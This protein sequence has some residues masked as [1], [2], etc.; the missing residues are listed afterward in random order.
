MKIIFFSWIFLFDSSSSAQTRP[1]NTDNYSAGGYTENLDVRTDRDIYI[2]G[3]QIWLK[4]YKLS[5]LTGCPDNLSKI[6]YVELLDTQFNPLNQIKV[7]VEGTSGSAYLRLSDTLTSGNYLIRAYTKWMLN[8]TADRDVYKPIFIINPF[9]KVFNLL[10]SS[11]DP[12]QENGN[13]PLTENHGS[14][15]SHAEKDPDNQINIKI[16]P[17]QGLYGQR[18]RVQIDINATDKS[19][20]PVDAD[21]FV[22]VVR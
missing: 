21:M 10:S 16:N 18:E 2:S 22:S 20:K 14:V 13:F 6:V 4:I 9:K 15:N 7:M 3:E 17:M 11:Y 8:S 5:G 12:N 1:D 19:G